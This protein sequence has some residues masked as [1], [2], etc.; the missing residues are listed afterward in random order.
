MRRELRWLLIRFANW[1]GGS[2]DYYD[3][4]EPVVAML[5]HKKSL[6]ICTNKSIF[7]TKDLK[8]YRKIKVGAIKSK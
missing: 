8:N 6:V 5:E 1:V 4:G 7:T 3:F 2:K